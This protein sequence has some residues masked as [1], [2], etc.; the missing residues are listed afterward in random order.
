MAAHPVGVSSF[1]QP[2]EYARQYTDAN[3]AKKN[4]LPPP[5]IPSE[6]T[7]FGEEYNFEEVS[8]FFYPKRF[9]FFFFFFLLN[10]DYFY[11]S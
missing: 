8:I 4:V 1:P 3:V 11:F 5:I 6:F 7:V 2:P 10:L 9:V